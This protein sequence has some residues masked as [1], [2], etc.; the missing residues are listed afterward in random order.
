M[1]GSVGSSGALAGTGRFECARQAEADPG[2]CR[3]F[4]EPMNILLLHPEDDPENGPWARHTW[5]RIVDLGIA[6]QDTDRRWAELFHCPVSPL[7]A[8]D[9]IDFAQL[10]AAMSA[11]FG[12]IVDQF[13]LDW[14][15]LISIEFH[16]QLE[17]LTRLQ[18]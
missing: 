4:V 17:V 14:W 8:L 12:M 15:E 9:A 1:A 5:D 11:G 18:K 10:R 16:Q 2:E 13:G 3:P 7:D 6:G